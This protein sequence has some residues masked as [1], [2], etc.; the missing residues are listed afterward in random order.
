M[1][2]RYACDRCGGFV[3]DKFL[4][5][6]LHFCLTDEEVKQRHYQ[7]MV[8]KRPPHHQEVSDHED[9]SANLKRFIDP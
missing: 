9:F 7:R 4:L 2:M 8:G 6:L 5:G 3:K 1:A